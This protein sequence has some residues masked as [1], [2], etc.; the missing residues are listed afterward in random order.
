MGA[1]A[2]L[3]QD[4]SGRL[5]VSDSLGARPLPNV[6]RGE[7]AGPGA[8]AYAV[9]DSARYARILFDRDGACGARR[10]RPASSASPGPTPP[11]R[12]RAEAARRN[13]RGQGRA[14]L[15]QGRADPGGPRGQYL[16][17]HLGRPRPPAGRQCGGRARDRPLLAL[18]LHAVRRPGRGRLG[19]RQR[20]RL[21]GPARPGAEAGPRSARQS[22]GALPGQGGRDVAGRQRRPDPAGKPAANGR[23]A[24]ST[25]LALFRMRDRRPR[26]PL[27]GPVRDRIWP[28]RRPGPMDGV[29]AAG[30]RRG[31][32]QYRDRP[33]RPRA[34]AQGENPDAAR[35]RRDRP[36]ASPAAQA[37]GRRHARLL[38]GAQRLPDRLRIRLAAPDGRPLPGP[39]GRA[40]S[41]GQGRPGHCPDPGGRDLDP[42][43]PGRRPDADSG[44][45][46]RVR[47][48][49][50][51]R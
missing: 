21:P 25:H 41:L 50:R 33:R 20:Q 24:G 2:G 16:D 42:G 49:R 40:L 39:A 26:R 27:V 28:P 46:P 47:R 12:P 17:R 23:P 6:A 36:D 3:A 5:W 51:D 31:L 15:Q 7:K 11:S 35:R 10:S 4:A 9:S 37:G 22:H 8:A 30:S 43:R 1:G 13:L 34:A 44:P 48:S 45:R 29:P 38:S 19:G 18:R 14:E 32:Q